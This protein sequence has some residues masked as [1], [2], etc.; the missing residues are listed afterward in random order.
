M[1]LVT[2]RQ[3]LF[4]NMKQ[5]DEYLERKIDPAYSFALDLIKKGVCFVALS[6]TNGVRFYPSRFI[7][8]KCNTIDKHLSNERKDGRETTPQI[9]N[10]IGNGSKPVFDLSLE[11]KYIEFCTSLGF[12]APEKGTF[13]IERKYWIY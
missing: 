13:G 6:D 2:N 12:E 10:I 11:R 4:E 5:I 1:D 7:G 3:E 9:S 8:Y